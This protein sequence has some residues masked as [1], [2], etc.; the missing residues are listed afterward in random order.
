MILLLRRLIAALPASSLH[1]VST[2]C[3]SLRFSRMLKCWMQA[4]RHETKRDLRRHFAPGVLPERHR[5]V[6]HDIS[7][8]SGAAAATV[9]V[10]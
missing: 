2:N 7:E 1:C 8:C 6:A 5:G 4:G 10:F 3:S 9:I